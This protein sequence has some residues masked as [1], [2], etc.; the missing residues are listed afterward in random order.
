[1]MGQFTKLSHTYTQIHTLHTI[2]MLK[3]CKHKQD[4]HSV[5]SPALPAPCFL[6]QKYI[7]FKNVD[8]GMHIIY[9]LKYNTNSALDQQKPH[10]EINEIRL[11]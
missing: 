2:E 5:V 7:F 10:L 8:G 6:H 3:I 11:E 4:T 9:S 1:M